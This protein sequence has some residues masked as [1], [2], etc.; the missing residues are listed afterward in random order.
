MASPTAPKDAD[1]TVYNSLN[2]GSAVPFQTKEAGKVA[3]Y[4]CGP[5]VYDLSHM[6]HARNYVSTDVIRRILLHYFGFQ[7]TFVMNITDVDDKIIVKARRKRL[8][9]LERAKPY[10]AAERRAL[11]TAAFVAYAEA[12]LPLLLSSSAVAGSSTGGEHAEPLSAETYAARRDAA[13]GAVLAGGTL[14]GEGR[15]GDAEA[16]TKMHL[17]NMNLAAQGLQDGGSVFND[18]EEILLPYLDA[19]YK[20]TIDTSDQTMFTDLTRSMEALFTADMDALNVL[21]PDAVTR[22]TEYVPQIVAFIEGIVRK[23][24]GYEANGSVYF[25]IAAFEQA[26]NTYAR[27]RPESRHDKALQE[28]GEGSLSKSLAGKRRPE[29]FALWKQSKPGEPFWPSPWGRGRPGWH[30]EC[31]VMASDK[32]G[33]QMD[34]HSGGIDLAFPH[35]DNE[36]AQSEAYFYEPGAAGAQPQQHR[37]VRYFFHMGH[38]SIAGSKM[39]KSL[40]NFQTIQD[41]L[42]TTYTARSMRIVFLFSRWNDGV[43]ISPDMRKQASN[44]ENT[45]D[46]F[47]TNIRARLAEAESAGLSSGVEK[48]SLGAD[49]KETT[50]TNNGSSS[51]IQAFQSDFAKAKADLDSALRNSFDTPAA[52]QVLLRLVRNANVY[53]SEPT[54]DLALLAS[55][56]RWVTKIVGVFGLDPNAVPP[57]ESGSIG[58]GPP[59]PTKS[60]AGGVDVDPETAVAPYRAAYAKVKEDVAAAVAAAA[61]TSATATTSLQALLAAQQ[62]DA[63]FAALAADNTRDVERL[64]LPY[65]RAVAGLRDELRRVA[66]AV[67]A[68]GSGSGS[69]NNGDKAT[70]GALLALSD[71]IRDYDLV[72]LGVQLDDQPNRPSLIKFVPVAKL[73]AARDE[74]AAAVAEKARLKAEAQRARE[75]AEAAKWDKAKVTPQALFRVA[76]YAAW[77]AEGVPTRL[78]DGSEVPKSTQKRL[79]KEWERQKKLHEA[80]LDKF[81]K[82]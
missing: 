51:S 42:A 79:K 68:S 19:L 23:G 3:W 29:D 49:E 76:A 75:A 56:A 9:E 81:G 12:N 25:D 46:N 41:A 2:P 40:K 33:A 39:S 22:V 66:A 24:F 17:A 50:T 58:W 36:L 63:E 31:S 62:P 67:S 37:W 77:D 7:V 70:K 55:V 52:M 38:L 60:A 4:A 71:R 57:Y 13:Y 78:A 43:E 48:L 20:E 32:L 53:M 28:E 54:A 80:Y 5:T 11:G 6:G 72:A 26:G 47:F 18:A 69:G 44:W 10:T 65:L 64:G 15:P 8:Y 16:K 14:T 21:R 61:V 27:L 45:L 74:K 73:V 82:A 34:I 1:I 35:H 59:N 30:I